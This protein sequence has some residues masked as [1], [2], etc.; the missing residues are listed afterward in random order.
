MS[1]S[2]LHPGFARPKTG[3]PPRP[4]GWV[5]GLEQEDWRPFARSLG[6]LLGSLAVLMFG[7]VA[8]LGG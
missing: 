4:A 8:L 7:L 3:A 6:T 2:V 5:G 1:Q